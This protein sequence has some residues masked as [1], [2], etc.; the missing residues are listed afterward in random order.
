M[1]QGTTRGVPIDIDPL[2]AAD[3][4]LL[5][6]SQKAIKTYADTKISSVSAT[7][8]IVSTGGTSPTLSIPQAT[9]SVN[10]YLSSADWSIFN[11]KQNALGFTPEDVANKQTDLTASATKYP[12]VNAV[13]TGLALKQN[14]LVYTPYK[15]IQTS[16]T[17]HTGT[18]AETLIFTA[19]IP[20]GSFNSTDVIK[21][22][23]GTNK[24]TA[25][26]TYSLRLRV[27]TTNTISGAPTI[28]LYSGTATAQVNIMMRN[29]NLN[30]G[31]LYGF[32]FTT[33][34]MTD[35]VAQG[36]ALGSTTLNPANQFYIFATI[37]LNNSGDSIIG[38]MFSIH[39]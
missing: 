2:L 38:N 7:S 35:I 13:N 12:T 18:T 1:A 19:T 29:Y 23:F 20:A 5:V 17:V 11:G 10:G 31:N 6:P 26:G 37:T 33:S 27:N 25:L 8:P 14:A 34:G 32:M 36:G 39:N 16:Q 21:V 24:S 15:N 30:G 22:L 4:D 28:A 9:S 3:S